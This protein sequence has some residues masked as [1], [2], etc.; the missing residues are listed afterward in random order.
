MYEVLEDIKLIPVLRKIPFQTS[1]ELI[2]ALIRGGIQAVEV[3]LDTENAL[4]IIAESRSHFG[5]EV[6]VGAGTVL[7]AEDCKNAIDAG[8][9]FIVSPLLNV[10]AVS[11]ANSQNIPVIPGVMTPSEIYAAYN[12]GAKMVKI[13]PASSVGASFIKDVK[14]PLS[15]ISIIATGGITLETA[16]SYLK[17]GADAIG[18][19]SDLLNKQLIADGNWLAIEKAA[20]QWT[21]EVGKYSLI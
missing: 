2:T 12:A 18:A 11:Y 8:A 6:L 19:G 14:G 21:L 15:D 9:Q 16:N 7:S 10:E 17:A 4:T 20:K 5:N 1:K 3:T 13:F